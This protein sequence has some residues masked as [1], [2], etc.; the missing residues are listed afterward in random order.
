MAVCVPRGSSRTAIDGRHV[1][2][3]PNC[4]QPFLEA[5]TTLLVLR[6]HKDPV[7]VALQLLQAHR[8][9]CRPCEIPSRRWRPGYAARPRSSCRDYKM[10]LQ[11]EHNDLL[12]NPCFSRSLRLEGGTPPSAPFLF[13]FCLV[14]RRVLSGCKSVRVVTPSSRRTPYPF[15]LH[16]RFH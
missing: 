5:S 4:S 11:T 8:S 13:T 3:S 6:I 10:A 2:S 12:G 14:F 15:G 16:A 9:P 7:Q 1:G